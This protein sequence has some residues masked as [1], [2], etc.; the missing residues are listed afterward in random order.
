MCKIIAYLYKY[1]SAFIAC[2]SIFVLATVYSISQLNFRSIFVYFDERRCHFKSAHSITFMRSVS[3][4]SAAIRLF[5]FIND[6]VL[7]SLSKR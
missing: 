4:S 1:I 3:V 7:I 6:G 5:G 2:G